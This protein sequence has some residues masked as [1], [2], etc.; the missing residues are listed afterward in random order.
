[1]IIRRS[2]FSR[3]HWQFAAKAAPT[4]IN[5]TSAYSAPLR[6]KKIKIIHSITKPRHEHHSSHHI[7]VA[8]V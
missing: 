8:Q 7:Q 3:E 5:K 6:F 2:G 4:D 1:M